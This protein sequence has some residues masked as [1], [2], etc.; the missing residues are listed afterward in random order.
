MVVRCVA[1]SAITDVCTRVQKA[2]AIVNKFCELADGNACF[3]LFAEQLL[4]VRLSP[5]PESVREVPSMSRYF[6]ERVFEVHVK[7]ACPKTGRPAMALDEFA[8]FLLAWNYRGQAPS[9]RC[10][11]TRCGLTTAGASCCV[12]PGCACA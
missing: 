11:L 8:D 4:H 12:Q 2:A 6:V 9:A 7:G 10:D 1:C 5:V 3:K